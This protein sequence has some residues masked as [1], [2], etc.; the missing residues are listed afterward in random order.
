M[1]ENLESQEKTCGIQNESRYD[2]MKIVPSKLKLIWSQ[3]YPLLLKSM[4][5][6]DKMSLQEIIEGLADQSI[7]F[8]IV[9]RVDEHIIDAVFLTSIE[10]DRGE[11]VL[12]LYN[13]GGSRAKE[14]VME[15]HKV[16][17]QFARFEDC[18]RVRL[19]GRP[20]WQRILPNYQVVGE[21]G[22]HLIYERP[23]D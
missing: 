10:R 11:W 22:G 20:A 13:L 1:H 3:A 17:H 2:V 4:S 12:S 9:A 16:M 14:W 19:C 21:R 5:A 18:R 15:C 6:N 23:V 8:W 7:Q